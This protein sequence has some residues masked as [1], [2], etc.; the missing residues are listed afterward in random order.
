[1][2]SQC[3]KHT[4]ESTVPCCNLLIDGEVERFPTVPFY[5]M[6]IQ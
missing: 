4:W 2:H 3:V 6:N 5:G 1:M